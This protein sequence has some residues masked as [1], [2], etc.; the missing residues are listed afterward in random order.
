MNGSRESIGTVG[1]IGLGIMGAPMASNLLGAGFDVVALNWRAAAS[2]RHVA[3]GGRV[4]DSIAEVTGAADVVI[5][6][7]PDG[8][9]V[10]EVALARDGVLASARRGLLYIDMSTIDVATTRRVSDAA[11][12][13]GVEALDAPVSGGEAGAVEGTL[14]IMVG[15]TETAY[16][17]ALP[18]FQA[19]GRTI[20]HVGP[21]GTGQ[22]VKA[23]NQLV[24]G[25]T[26]ALVAEAIVFLE[27]H[28][29]EMES[30]IEVLAGGLAGNRILDRKSRGMLARDFTPGFRVDLHHKDMGIVLDAA[31]A[32]GV[33]VPTGA[34]VGQLFGALR[35]RGDGALDHTALLRLIESLSG[36]DEVSAPDEP[37]GR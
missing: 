23:A 28:H 15:G 20:A 31:R 12:Q 36:R 7:L 33:T 25:G 9:A 10:A 2:Q 16:E 32:A 22:I 11:Q 17:Q 14:S 5:T 27:A 35:A 34:L 1:F 37:S 21:T 30:A 13:A 3:A 18:L 29:V 8:P 19:M 6:M 26:I 4:A 24:V